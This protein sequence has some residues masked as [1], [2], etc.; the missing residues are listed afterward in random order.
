MKLNEK[1]KQLRKERNWSQGKL[2]QKIGLD[3]RQVCRYEKGIT[4]P[5]AETLQKL[6]SAFD[7]PIDFLV[8]EN[9][10]ESL[11]NFN[12]KDKDLLKYFQGIDKMG[13]EE[14]KAV[15]FVLESVMMR[16]KMKEFFDK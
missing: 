5:S 3:A 6:A 4:K 16:N 7:V 14:R 13:E 9:E 8:T 10:E 11:K 12:I 1:I 15:K 2:G